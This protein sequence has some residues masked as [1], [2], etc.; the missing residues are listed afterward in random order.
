MNKWMSHAN[1]FVSGRE[2]VTLIQQQHK[3]ARSFF[4]LLSLSF[5]FSTTCLTYHFSS[6]TVILLDTTNQNSLDWTR[7]PYGPSSRTPGVSCLLL[8]LLIFNL[9]LAVPSSLT[10]AFARIYLWIVCLLFTWRVKERDH[11]TLLTANQLS[12]PSHDGHEGTFELSALLASLYSICPLVAIA[13]F[14]ASF[15]SL[16][17]SSSHK[18]PSFTCDLLSSLQ[19]YLSL[20][21]LFLSL[22]FS[23]VYLTGFT[24]VSIA[25]FSSTTTCV[26]TTLT[27]HQI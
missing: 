9:P 18:S 15:L 1:E 7:Y 17:L 14:L 8:L 13:I 6:L 27:H 26:F 25:L 3:Q 16:S 5:F 21:C 10:P 4:L 20:S 22:P 24:W 12:H 11:K 2:N 19:E 23:C